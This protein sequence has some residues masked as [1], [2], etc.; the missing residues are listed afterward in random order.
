[1]LHLYVDRFVAEYDRVLCKEYGTPASGSAKL[2]IK[3]DLAHEALARSLQSPNFSQ[4]Q[5]PAQTKTRSQISSHLS[6]VPLI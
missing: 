3:S 1:M 5:T 4:D 2:K 6:S